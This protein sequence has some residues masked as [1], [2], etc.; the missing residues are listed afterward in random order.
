MTSPA[1]SVRAMAA[2]DVGAVARI[3]RAHVAPTSSRVRREIRARIDEVIADAGRRAVALVGVDDHDRVAGYLIG[4]VRS[5]EFGSEPAGWI[6]ALGVD[7]RLAR[8]GLGRLLLN[9]AARSFARR[10]IHTVRT[11]VRRDDVPVLR[12]FRG[13]HFNG[14]P[15]LELELELGLGAAAAAPRAEVG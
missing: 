11:M 4:D 8:R 14:G 13:E 12:F 6:F 1:F 2:T 7:P 10:G 5:W 15:Y 9:E 3:Y